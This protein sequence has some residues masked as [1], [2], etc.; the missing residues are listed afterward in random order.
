MFENI[1][2]SAKVAMVNGEISPPS[3]IH[4]NILC[5]CNFH[6]RIFS[7]SCHQK[8]SCV[9][10]EVDQLRIG[11]EEKVFTRSDHLQHF[12]REEEFPIRIAFSFERCLFSN[13]REDLVIVTFT[14][15]DCGEFE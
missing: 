14:A 3:F 7:N 13:V 8:F 11:Q 12:H 5:Q 9:L 1:C 2:Q 4:I 6:S 10:I 15:N